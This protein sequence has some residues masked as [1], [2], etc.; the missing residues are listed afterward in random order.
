MKKV[1]VFVVFVKKKNL[2]LKLMIVQIARDWFVGNAHRINAKI[3]LDI[4]VN[5]VRK[6]NED[7][8]YGK[9]YKERNRVILVDSA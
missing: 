6:R 9:Y 2:F 1:M 3:S 7:L 8:F 5:H 4:S